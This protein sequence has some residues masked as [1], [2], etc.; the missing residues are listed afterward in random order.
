MS[1]E[2]VIECS[3]KEADKEKQFRKIRENVEVGEETQQGV[4]DLKK[5][6]KGEA[7]LQTMKKKG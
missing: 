2:W 5:D 7:A 6:R 3:Y 4:R 1:F